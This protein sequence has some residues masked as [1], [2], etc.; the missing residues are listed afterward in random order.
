[1]ARFTPL[2]TAFML[3]L[4]LALSACAPAIVGVSTAAVAAS[5]TEKRLF[6]ICVRWGYSHKTIR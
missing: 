4:S 1:M 2:L 3:S 5:S 6:N